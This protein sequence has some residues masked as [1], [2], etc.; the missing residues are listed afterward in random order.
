M[1]KGFVQVLIE[2]EQVSGIG[3]MDAFCAFY[4]DSQIA[5]GEFDEEIHL[6]AIHGPQVIE[7]GFGTDRFG[8]FVEFGHDHAFELESCRRA[9]LPHD[10]LEHSVIQKMEFGCLDEALF[11]IARPGRQYEYLVAEFEIAEVAAQKS[12]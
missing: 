5:Y 9:P 12:A 6:P 10:R 11:L 4:L 1:E 3:G 2:M 7:P 8:L